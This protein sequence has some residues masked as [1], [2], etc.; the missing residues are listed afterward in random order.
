MHI[1]P[2]RLEIPYHSNMT[3]SIPLL[4]R[5]V[6]FQKPK[7]LK[8][9]MLRYQRDTLWY[10]LTLQWTME[11]LA[12]ILEG[13]CKW[14]CEGEKDKNYTWL[15]IIGRAH[16][17]DFWLPMISPRGILGPGRPVMPVPF[18]GSFP[19]VW[20][21]PADCLGSIAKPDHCARLFST[22]HVK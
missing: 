9:I 14:R 4:N 2:N 16:W 19:K 3:L 5:S 13:E 17:L 21:R 18:L 10:R 15:L 12:P 22:E 7:C 11:H 20:N 1:E 6:P 8:G